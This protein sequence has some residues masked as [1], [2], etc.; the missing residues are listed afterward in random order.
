MLILS[1]INPEQ[2]LSDDEA[3]LMELDLAAVAA[4]ST[5]ALERL[6]NTAKAAVYSYSLSVLRNVQDAEDVLHDAFIKTAKSIKQIDDIGSRRTAAYLTVITKNTAYDR[7]RR[8][9]RLNETPIDTCEL[10]ADDALIEELAEKTE[11]EDLIAAI[12]SVPT[13]YNEVLFLHYVNELPV[14]KT[15]A[16]LERKVSTVKMQLV[17]GK[18]LLL[19]A[20]RGQENE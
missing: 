7:L 3:E 2:A 5:E 15:A 17:R 4:G 1:A 14:K 6:Y 16:L 18:K 19:Q 12:K 10:A 11:Y 8:L 9:K 20:L 13:P